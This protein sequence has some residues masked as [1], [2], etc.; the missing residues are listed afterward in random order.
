MAQG[1]REEP[2]YSKNK[3]VFVCGHVR[4]L[5]DIVSATI[6]FWGLSRRDVEALQLDQATEIALRIRVT[7]VGN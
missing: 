3:V 2:V 4:K 5:C 7:K 1:G 6:T